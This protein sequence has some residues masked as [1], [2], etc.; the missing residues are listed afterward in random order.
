MHMETANII[1]I[2]NPSKVEY[3]SA[4]KQSFHIIFANQS[5]MYFNRPMYIS[6]SVWTFIHMR[7]TD[8]YLIRVQKT[9]DLYNAYKNFIHR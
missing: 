8:P 2:E 5:G 9:E 1:E 3:I 7:H 4:K 6:T